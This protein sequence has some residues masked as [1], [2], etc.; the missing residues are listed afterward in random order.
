M[1]AQPSWHMGHLDALRGI[2]VLG[3]VMVHSA[4]TASGT[5]LPLRTVI[6][7]VTFTGQRG[8]AL[9]FVVSA[10]TLFL[11]L[12][13]RRQ[14]HRP[15]LN[16]FLRRFF[17]IAPMF[18]I[19]IAVTHIFMG[20][21]AGSFWQ[22]IVAFFFVHAL[23]PKTINAGAAGGWSVAD[24]ALFYFCLPFLF[25]RIRTLNR[26]I[27]W[28]ITGSFIGGILSYHLARSFPVYGEY[29]EFF[30]FSAEF[31]VFLIGIC[32]YFIWK[33]LI[34]GVNWSDTGRRQVSVLLLIVAAMLYAALLPF[35]NSTLYQSTAVCALLL[36][37][38]SFHPWA[39]LVNR[40]TRFLGKISYSVYLLHFTV[41]FYLQNWIGRTIPTH[42]ILNRPQLR[43]AFSFS[44]ILLVTV[45]LATLTWLWIEEPGIRAGRKLINRLEQTAK[46]R[47]AFASGAESS[48]QPTTSEAS[49]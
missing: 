49:W 36:V 34:V 19:A 31:P 24:E 11:S 45:P 25:L 8:V 10:F 42:G 16:F 17:R 13:N 32:A 39:I 4:I 29:F 7:W 48:G 20:K 37:A 5:G 12:D 1:R 21:F 23:S 15:F 46:K 22:N 28:A 43:F 44:V 14:E 9:F 35:T 40:V 27:V 18:Y 47:A 38:L 6:G 3:V 2:A 30:S 33:T 26:A 41:N